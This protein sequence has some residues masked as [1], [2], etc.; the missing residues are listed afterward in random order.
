M[1]SE[2]C[3]LYLFSQW[4]YQHQSGEVFMKVGFP[5]NNSRVG[6]ASCI[7]L[8][9][10]PKPDGIKEWDVFVIWWTGGK[11]EAKDLQ[12]ERQWH[13]AYLE[14]PG[15]HSFSY[16][17]SAFRVQIFNSSSCIMQKIPLKPKRLLLGAEI[18]PLM[19]KFWHGGKCRTR[20]RW[21]QG[22]V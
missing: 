12:S 3:L 1:A 2:F 21:G 18:A 16:S 8:A 4:K 13:P 15:F 19:P 5:I 11:E 6:D 9:S 20:P 22:G 14:L 10:T 17:S 7:Q